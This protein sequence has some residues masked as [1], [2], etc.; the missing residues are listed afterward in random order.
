MRSVE[1]GQGIWTS[2]AMLI[3][4]ELEVGLDQVTLVAAPANPAVYTD[5]MLHE[6]ATGGSG[7]TR[8]TWVQL[9]QAGAVGRT[10]L[11]QAAAAAVGR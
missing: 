11:V 1:M 2:S 8:S 10:M 4:E 7:S 6:Q 3:A 5:P 9:R